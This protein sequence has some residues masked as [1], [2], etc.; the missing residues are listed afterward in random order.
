MADPRWKPGSQGR[1]RGASSGSGRAE[2]FWGQLTNRLDDWLAFEPDGII[3][4]FSGKVEL[5]TGVRTALAQIVAE[6]LDVPFER[7]RMVMGDTA[8]TPNEGFTAGSMTIQAS[9]SALR[10]AAAEARRA[11]LQM[12]SDLLDAA[13]EE[14]EVRDGTIAVSHHPDRTV[15][16]AELIGGKRFNREVTGNAPLKRPEEYRLVGT[17][18][19][20]LDIPQIVAG[21]H[22]FI[23]DLV[24]PGMLHGRLVRPP[25]PGATL[26]SIDETSIRDLP[27][28][29]KVVHLGN[30]A[31]VVAER[32][33]QA[34]LAAE[35]LA[36]SWE[37][38]S[39]LPGNQNLYAYL[40]LQPTQDNVLVDTGDIEARLNRAAHHLHAVY[41]QPYHAHASVGPS[42]AVADVREG[43][44]TVWA[45]T[46]G[47]YPLRGALAQLAGVPNDRVR[48]INVEGA[49]SYGHNGADDVAAD[50]VVLSREVGRPVRVQWSR[51]Q[52]FIWE[53]K[54]P[55]GIM[56]VD[57]GLDENGQVV[58]WDYR[59]WSPSHASRSF[60]ADQLLTVHLITG[61]P[62]PPMPFAFGA[63][64]NARTNYA[65]PHQRV[66]VHYLANSLLRTSA[67][68][69]LGGTEN[70]F[71]NESFMDELAAAAQ[72]DAIE[73]RLRYLNDPRAQEVIKAAATRAGWEAHPSP[74][75]KRS[76]DGQVAFGRG[77]A[78]AQYENDQAIVATIIN[79]QVDLTSGEVRV[80]DVVIAH[81]CGLIINPNGLKNQIEGNVIQSLS[82]ALKEEV[83]F[84]QTR[85]TSVDWES[86]P[87]LKFTEVPEIEII[88]INRPHLP[89][90]GAG[91]PS[92][93][94]TAAAVANA[95]FDATGARLR[96]LPFTPERVKAGIEQML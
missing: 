61:Q 41:E 34:I 84:D 75:L 79:L 3:L 22:G 25:S 20:R 51:E 95:I 48:L 87:I 88:L 58:A 1:N 21:Q 64:R 60:I 15:S 50:A 38:K 42:C 80:Q 14:L 74:R 52:E 4:A 49:G 57:G 56:E 24:V 19:P 55:A 86:Y 76:Q 70:T 18:V 62:A 5:G 13:V 69:S 89:A 2:A 65:F 81:D 31:G 30:F 6:E 92:T 29:V 33:E 82:R 45:A 83:R 36:V 9:G 32:E 26:V 72:V 7:V 8:L 37:E 17:S 10:N 67:F 63:E 54:G 11:L 35:R 78:F 71:A 59:I 23:Q 73:F 40:R 77:I 68:R 53:P 46:A 43:Q 96:R 27:G 85:I 39:A 12:A 47:P 91:E 93:V 90:V 28:L 94:T 44:V 66:T 16:Y